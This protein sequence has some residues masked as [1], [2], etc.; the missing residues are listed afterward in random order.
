MQAL[1]VGQE[2]AVLGTGILGYLLSNPWPNPGT[3]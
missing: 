2:T 1:E 3:Y